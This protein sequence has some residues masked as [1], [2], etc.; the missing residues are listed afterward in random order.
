[1][2]AWQQKTAL[3]AVAALLLFG[4]RLSATPEQKLTAEGLTDS[5]TVVKLG[6][7]PAVDL[8]IFIEK[9]P[10]AKPSALR[11]QII[12]TRTGELLEWEGKILVPTA[13]RWFEITPQNLAVRTLSPVRLPASS[14]A[15][16][17]FR[18][19]HQGILAWRTTGPHGFFQVTLPMK[20]GR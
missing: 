13:R 8:F 2:N 20:N 5:A 11:I 6:K 15:I 14:Y 19:W 3:S 4:G 12:E 1:M 10:K 16:R 7:L 17:H 18:S 9:L